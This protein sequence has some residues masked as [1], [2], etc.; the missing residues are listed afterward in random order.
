MRSHNIRLHWGI[1]QKKFWIILNT[2]SYLELCFS[3]G[4]NLY[5]K[6]FLSS[7][8]LNVSFKKRLQLWKALIVQGHKQEVTK[9]VFPRKVAEKHGCISSNLTIP[10]YLFQ[11]TEICFVCSVE[12]KSS[13]HPS[14]HPSMHIHPSS[15]PAPVG[16]NMSQ[17]NDAMPIWSY[18]I[19]CPYL[20][21]INLPKLKLEEPNT[22]IVYM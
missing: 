13:I 22:Q 4:V 2:P 10:L 15:Q 3:S 21:K 20:N 17:I 8:G 5:G 9:V 6:E 18:S 12:H 1:R 11:M 7:L 19:K 16:F 14:I